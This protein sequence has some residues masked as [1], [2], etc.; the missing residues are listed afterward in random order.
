MGDIGKNNGKKDYVVTR[1]DGNTIGSG[2][3]DPVPIFCGPCTR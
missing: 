3:S 1:E 2:E